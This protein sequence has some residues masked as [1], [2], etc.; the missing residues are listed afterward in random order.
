MRG[1]PLTVHTQAC[2]PGPALADAPEAH[3]LRRLGAAGPAVRDEEGDQST[4]GRHR[5]ADRAGLVVSQI[6]GPAGRACVQVVM[7]WHRHAIEQASRRWRGGGATNP[8]RIS[9][10]VVI[11]HV[12]LMTAALRRRRDARS[13]PAR[14][15]IR[16]RG[17]EEAPNVSHPYAR[18]VPFGRWLWRPY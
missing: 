12:L 2:P 18:L 4:R 3:P 10:I 16:G 6:D 8:R 14:A 15:I 1:A 17:W 5:R 9:L 11:S 7:N 13:R